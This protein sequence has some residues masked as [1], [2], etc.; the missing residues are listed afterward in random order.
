MSTSYSLN[1]NH[2][3]YVME[4]KSNEPMNVL[5][6]S[7]EDPAKA[8]EQRDG[9]CLRRGGQFPAHLMSGAAA[10]Q[11]YLY[12]QSL[13]PSM[14]KLQIFVIVKRLPIIDSV[15]KRPGS[16]T[17]LRVGAKNFSSFC[18]ESTHW[19]TSVVNEREGRINWKVRRVGTRCSNNW[20]TW[21]KKGRCGLV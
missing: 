3:R 14:F 5:S 4:L 6:I 18:T 17:D 1:L 7:W 16:C 8:K 12:R 15:L 11:S 2:L 19:A 10:F 20:Q 9:N 21:L 13:Y